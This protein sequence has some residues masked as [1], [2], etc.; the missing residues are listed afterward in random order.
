MAQVLTHEAGDPVTTPAWITAEQWAPLK[1]PANVLAL[2]ATRSSTNLLAAVAAL[3]VTTAQRYAPDLTHTWCNVYAS[4]LLGILRAP[5][6]R[7]VA[8]RELTINEVIGGLRGRDFVFRDWTRLAG[9]GWASDAKTLAR[10]FDLADAGM[11]TIAT[12]QNPTGHGHIAVLV[13]G[14][15]RAH[16]IFVSCAG[17]ICLERGPIAQAFGA[18]LPQLEF[19]G[20]Q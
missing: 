10:L 11:P 2:G 1:P 13:P 14:H 8:G 20:H 6:P 9:A 18:V 12:Y 4:D 17:R 3:H 19:W 7:I 15:D 5:L 16:G